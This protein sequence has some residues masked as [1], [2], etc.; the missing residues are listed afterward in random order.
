MHVAPGNDTFN[1]FCGHIGERT[2]ACSRPKT[3]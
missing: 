3:A 1:Y 2:A